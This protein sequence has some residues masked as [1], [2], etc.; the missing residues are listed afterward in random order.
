[1]L[2]VQPNKRAVCWFGLV[3]LCVCATFKQSAHKSQRQPAFTKIQNCLIFLWETLPQIC[4]RLFGTLGT[5]LS[6]FVQLFTQQ[7]Y[8]WERIVFGETSRL[9][10]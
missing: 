4:F 7:A 5:K 2:A 10:L 9:E 1:M 3:G 6:I 8:S